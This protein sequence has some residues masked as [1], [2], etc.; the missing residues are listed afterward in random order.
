MGRVK[1]KSAL[2]IA[3]KKA[4][5]DAACEEPGWKDRHANERIS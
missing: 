3:M 2:E 5:E 4:D 1:V